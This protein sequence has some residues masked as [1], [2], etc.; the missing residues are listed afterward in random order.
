MIGLVVH[1]DRSVIYGEYVTGVQA[2]WLTPRATYVR[3]KLL[4]TTGKT[5]S[6]IQAR[7]GYAV[8]M[9]QFIRDKERYYGFSLSFMKIVGDKLDERNEYTSP[10]VGGKGPGHEG[11]DRY[12][13]ARDY[14]IYGWEL[15]FG[16]ASDLPDAKRWLNGI[17]IYAA[18]G[19]DEK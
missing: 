7:S 14:P 9:I 1:L 5:K 10:H 13:T 8:S 11:F 12:V 15:H 19:L 6:E 3:G 2:I 17:K 4:G 16:A 18:R